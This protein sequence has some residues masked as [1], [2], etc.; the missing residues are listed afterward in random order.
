[1]QQTNRP[2][3]SNNRKMKNQINPSLRNAKLRN[4]K[5]KDSN[6][7]RYANKRK[8]NLNLNPTSQNATKQIIQKDNYNK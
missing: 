1:M 3:E 4:T 6:T 5:A 2:K 7:H 8:Q